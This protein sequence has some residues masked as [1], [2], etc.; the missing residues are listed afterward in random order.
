MFENRGSCKS[1]LKGLAGFLGS[2]C[3]WKLGRFTIEERHE[4]HCNET[5]IS[6]NHAVE[7]GKAQESLELHDCVRLGPLSHCLDF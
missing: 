4:R 1:V 7:I 5:V 3:L 6:E 2:I